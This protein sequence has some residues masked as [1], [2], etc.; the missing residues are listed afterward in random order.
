MLSKNFLSY[1]YIIMNKECTIFDV[2]KILHFLPGVDLWGDF[3][4]TYD[5]FYCL[6]M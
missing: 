2:W 3:G 4:G 5:S 6:F 1:L